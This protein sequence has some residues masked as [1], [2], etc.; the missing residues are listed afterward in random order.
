MTGMSHDEVVES[1]QRGGEISSPI[2]EL[3][4]RGLPE[5]MQRYLRYAGVVG[6][7]SIQT[8]RLKQQGCMRTQPGQRWMP[9]VAEQDFTTNPPAFAW[10]ATVRLFPPVSISAI[11]EFSE[12]HGSMRIKLLSLIP[13]GNAQGPE[14][15]QGELQRY[16]GEMIWFP[17]VWLAENIEW[18]AIDANS[19]QATIRQREV[20]ASVTLHINEQ[21]QLISVTA[22]RYMAQGKHYQLA[23]W[24][25]Q[26]GEYQ[27]ADGMRIPTRVEVTWHLP[28]GDFT[29]FR[30]KISEIEYNR[31]GKVTSF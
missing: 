8:V 7:E 26:A 1:R 19:V 17:T 14:M 3:Q 9:L 22:Q 24:S 15:D 6:K 4:V 28:S 27:E 30:V 2:T 25:V 5:P 21:G 12:G 11:D 16:L 23:P 20:T 29:W 10:R 31:S 18:Q 13:M